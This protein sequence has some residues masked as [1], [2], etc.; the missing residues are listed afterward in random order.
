[1]RFAVTWIASGTHPAYLKRRPGGE[2]AMTSAQPR[3]GEGLRRLSP[4]CTRVMSLLQPL[5]QNKPL[6]RPVPAHGAEE[7]CGPQLAD[8]LPISPHPPVNHILPSGHASCQCDLVIDTLLHT[9]SIA[10]GLH[11]LG[12]H[13]SPTRA[14]LSTRSWYLQSPRPAVTY[15]SKVFGATSAS[16]DIHQQSVWCESNSSPPELHGLVHGQVHRRESRP[17]GHDAR[18][19]SLEYF[20]SVA[21]SSSPAGSPLQC[22]PRSPPDPASPCCPHPPFWLWPPHCLWRQPR[23]PAGQPL[24]STSMC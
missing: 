20:I 4:S 8:V 11:W 15:T 5:N 10:G 7:K 21:I 17:D 14:R 13:C 3:G 22:S 16:S 6:T 18:G 24:P 19:A 9:W 12:P 23:R 2:E 1:M